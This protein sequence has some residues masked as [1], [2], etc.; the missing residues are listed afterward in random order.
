MNYQMIANDKL[1]DKSILYGIRRD[2]VEYYYTCKSYRKTAPLFGI[3]VKT[4]VKW[5]NG[6]KEEG[7]EE[8]R[9]LPRTPKKIHNKTREEVEDIIVKL[10]R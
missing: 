3:N 10:R 7:L 1:K 8:L 2:M 5:V 9:D 4:V 6:F